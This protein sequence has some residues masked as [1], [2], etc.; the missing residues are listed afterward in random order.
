MK[1]RKCLVQ[2]LLL[3][4]EAI[5]VLLADEEGVAGDKLA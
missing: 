2:V 1:K 5:C 4:S 3:G